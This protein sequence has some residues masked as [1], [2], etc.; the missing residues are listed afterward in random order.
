MGAERR[1]SYYIDPGLAEALW[2][3]DNRSYKLV[4][5]LSGAQ[6]GGCKSGADLKWDLYVEMGRETRAQ[7]L[8]LETCQ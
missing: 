3:R 1:E 2:I 4:D 8:R 5:V 6:M 7:W